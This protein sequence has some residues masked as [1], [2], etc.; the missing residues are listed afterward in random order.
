MIWPSVLIASLRVVVQVT[1]KNLTETRNSVDDL[2]EKALTSGSGSRN[3]QRQQLLV[4]K[5][6]GQLGQ[7]RGQP[8]IIT[9]SRQAAGEVAVP[10]EPFEVFTHMA[11]GP[12]V[13]ASDRGE[14]FPV[15]FV[16]VDGTI[17]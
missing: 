11:R 14:V 9:V 7:T 2:S 15:F 12:S 1:S 5:D 16:R 4:L 6:K 13:V 10:F 8:A 17:N 3:D